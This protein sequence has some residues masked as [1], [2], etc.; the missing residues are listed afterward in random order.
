MVTMHIVV[1]TLTVSSRGKLPEL[2]SQ[3]TNTLEGARNAIKNR[4]KEIFS[5]TEF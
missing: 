5:H 2:I 1:V 3:R 4:N